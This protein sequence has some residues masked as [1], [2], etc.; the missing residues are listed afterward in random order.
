V[1]RDVEI[2]LQ[3]ATGVRQKRPMRVDGGTELVR[4][5]QVVGRD[6]HETAVADLHLAVELQQ[7]FVL[8][9]FLGTITPAREHQRGRVALLQ[10]RGLAVLAALVGKLVVG[11][12]RAG[13]DVGPHLPPLS[14]W[15]AAPL[16]ASSAVPP[17]WRAMM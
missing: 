8:P 10:L 17:R 4:L 11:K 14:T 5:E 2:L 13:D 6:G 3:L 16:A 15:R 9:S 12:D 1:F 7:P